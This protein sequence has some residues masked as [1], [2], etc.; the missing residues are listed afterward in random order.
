MRPGAQHPLL[1]ADRPLDR[2]GLASPKNMY[3]TYET[4]GGPGRSA[5]HHSLAKKSK[6]S[7]V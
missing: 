5:V 7:E 4:T 2:E 6:R 3:V 1:K